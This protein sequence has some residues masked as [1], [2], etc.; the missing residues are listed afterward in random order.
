[1]V[2]TPDNSQLFV[3]ITAGDCSTDVSGDY[4]GINT[5]IGKRESFAISRLNSNFTQMTHADF[6]LNV[7]VGAT[8]TNIIYGTSS[9]NGVDN[10]PNQT[11]AN[12]IRTIQLSTATLSVSLTANGMFIVDNPSGDGGQ[13]SFKMSLAA[14]L[15]DLAGRTLH[16]F[17]FPDDAAPTQLSLTIGTPGPTSVSTFV[18]FKDNS[19][20]P[21]GNS[22]IQ[23]F[24]SLGTS[25]SDPLSAS[26]VPAKDNAYYSTN[27][28]SIDYPT[29]A[30]VPGLFY[31]PASDPTT[32]DGGVIVGGLKVNGKVIL[33]GVVINDRSNPSY[34]NLQLD[35]SVALPITGNFIAF[36]Q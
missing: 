15:A 1:M 35:K 16:G 7:P 13:V 3:G 4:V 22:S 18:Q 36:E 25:P 8:K 21:Q 12:G 31:I 30:Q 28:L 19:S 32:T 17:A 14:T 24:A 29:L 11:C 10:L 33:V 2:L 9:P 34:G 27:V 6:K 26:Q 23:T 20:I 5:S